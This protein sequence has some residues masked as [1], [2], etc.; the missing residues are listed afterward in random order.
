MDEQNEP[1]RLRG[2][3]DE[4]EA[5]WAVVV[6]DD[7]QRLDWPRAQLPQ[8]ASVGDAVVIEAAPC[9]EQSRPSAAVAGSGVWVGTVGVQAQAEAAQTLIHLG[10]QALCWP[11]TGWAVGDEVVVQI[12]TDADDTQRRRGQVQALID[13]LFG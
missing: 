12:T 3:I 13:D 1:T 11:V 10:D 2:V 4:L 8:D 6:L 5:E 9:L 7:G